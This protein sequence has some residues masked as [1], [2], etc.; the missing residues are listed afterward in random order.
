MNIEIH[1]F[2]VSYSILFASLYSSWGSHGEY[3][4]VVCHSLFYEDKHELGQTLGDGE[5]QRSLACCSPWGHEESDVT[6][7]LKN[8]SKFT[9][10]SPHIRC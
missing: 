10:L 7:L 4:G 5:G 6:R 1:R 8:K 3:T 2:K 9:H